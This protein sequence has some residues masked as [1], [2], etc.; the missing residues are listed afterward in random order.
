MFIN[1]ISEFEVG[2][3]FQDSL[4]LE[5]SDAISFHFKEQ[6]TFQERLDFIK[7]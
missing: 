1:N 7:T 2:D 4:P 3:I 6:A 5:Y